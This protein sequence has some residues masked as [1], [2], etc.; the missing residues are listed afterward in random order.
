MTRERRRT[1]LAAFLLAAYRQGY[2]SENDPLPTSD[3]VEAAWR[4]TRG[5]R[6]KSAWLRDAERI[7]GE[8]GIE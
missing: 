7:L 8:M 1:L 3:G 6:L 5:R 4:A 2:N